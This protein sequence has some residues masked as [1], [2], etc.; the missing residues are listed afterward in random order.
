MLTASP[1][2]YWAVVPAA[3]VGKRMSLARPKQYLTLLGQTVIEHTLELFLEH[4]RVCGVV[5]VLAKDDPYWP[6]LP[7]S[8]H[9]ALYTARGG[10]ERYHSVV[11]GL[12]RLGDLADDQDWVLVHDAARPCLRRTDLEA[13]MEQ[14]ANDPVG[15]LLACPVRDTM[16]R[17]DAE[18][19]VVGTVDRHQLWHALTPQM[20]RLGPLRRALRG[21]ME[22][23][24]SVTDEAAAME[25]DGLRPRLVQGHQDNI[26]ITS[27][28]D[29]P[30][31][32]LLLQAQGREGAFQAE[33]DP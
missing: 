11:N 15:G 7:I 10:A 31:A 33:E 6:Q 4:Q 9:P 28:A 16:K 14:L 29:L 8:R 26:K 23:D 24:S 22:R 13:L 2:K 21:A 30:L 32:A 19:S 20:F 18:G 12:L 5:V 1:P 25:M 3:G 17:G 27:P